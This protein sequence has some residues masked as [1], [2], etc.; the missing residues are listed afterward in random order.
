MKDLY[1]LLEVDK[2]ATDKEIKLAY[3][4]LVK[5]NHPDLIKGKEKEFKA[6]KEAYNVLSNSKRRQT[7][8]ITGSTTEITE[9]IKIEYFKSVFEGLIVNVITESQFQTLSDVIG[10]LNKMMMKLKD[11]KK[12]IANKVEM[13]RNF[14]KKIHK[15]ENCNPQFFYENFIFKI[16]ELQNN[17]NE[18]SVEIEMFDELINEIYK[19]HEFY[20]SYQDNPNSKIMLEE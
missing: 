1:E 13:L 3:K 14:Y 20:Y 4:R 16:E 12:E 17:E 6:I 15:K 7:Y 11:K 18:L 10:E 2:K 9:K 5:L 19:N 8:D